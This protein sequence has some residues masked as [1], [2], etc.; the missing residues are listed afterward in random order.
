MLVI[1]AGMLGRAI[2]ECSS[3]DYESQVAAQFAA[4]RVCSVGRTRIEC[5]RA[6]WLRN[7]PPRMQV[8]AVRTRLA[9]QCGTDNQCHFWRCTGT[10]ST[11]G[12]AAWSV[13]HVVAVLTCSLPCSVHETSHTTTS[14]YRR[15]RRRSFMQPEPC[16]NAVKHPCDQPQ[17][18]VSRL[19]VVLRADL[20][21]S[22]TK[23]DRSRGWLHMG[24]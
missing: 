11:Q 21:R 16:E 8:D 3:A 18:Q 2:S 20:Q 17:A 1:I 4:Q 7:L 5:Q 15:P 14:P 9:P 6:S 10:L 24:R 19:S 13:Q 23:C 22:S 12:S